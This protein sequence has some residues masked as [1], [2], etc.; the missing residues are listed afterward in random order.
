MATRSLPL[1][2]SRGRRGSFI[3]RWTTPEQPA[4][5]ST[6]GA[7]IAALRSR[8]HLSHPLG[9]GGI[10]FGESC[11]VL[12]DGAVL[13][14]ERD[15]LLV[16]VERGAELAD[17]FKRDRQVVVSPRVSRIEGDRVLK[18]KTRFLPVTEPRDPGSEFQLGGSL[19]AGR[20]R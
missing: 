14:I 8:A 7:R 11:V 18:A 9:V 2:G 16:F 20:G 19:L 6:S 15:G 10:K 17:R 5:R 4:A 13:C 1:S 3:L 12:L